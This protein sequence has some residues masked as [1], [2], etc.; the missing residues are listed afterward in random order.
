M[1]TTKLREQLL[2][3]L[4]T[5][6]DDANKKT[7]VEEAKTTSFLH[8]DSWYRD[9]VFLSVTDTTLDTFEV[10][11]E[12]VETREQHDLW[13]YFR[14][15]TSSI[16][17]NRNA[18]RNMRML[19]KHKTTQ[20]YIGILAL[21]G[22]V[23]RCKA[24][25]TTIGWTSS[26]IRTK[27]KYVMNIA[28]CVGL[29]PMS[30]N[31]NIG[32]L[33]V[34]LCFSRT[35][36]L[37]FKEKYGHDLACITTFSINGTSIQY[38]R[39]P[40]YLKYVGE[41]KGNIS[42]NI[43]DSLYKSCMDYLKDLKDTRAL[44]WTNKMYKV[45][46]VLS[47]LDIDVSNIDNS[48]IVR[49][50]GVYIGFISDDAKP[51][52]SCVK[53][54]FSIDY[55]TIDDVNTIVEWWKHR[56]ASRRYQHLKTTNRLRYKLEL[57]NV[58]KHKNL[59]DVKKAQLRNREQI[60]EEA[61]KEK[62]R[63]YMAKYRS[64]ETEI[65]TPKE[66]DLL[67]TQYGVQ[68]IV[69]NP[70]WLAGFVDGDG[71]ID[72]IDNKYLRVSICQCDPIVLLKIQQV[73]GGSL[74]QKIN[75]GTGSRHIYNL[76]LHCSNARKII[77]DIAN[78]VIIEKQKVDACLEYFKAYDMADPE[79]ISRALDQVACK[80]KTSGSCYE[81]VCYAYIAGLFDA[82]GEVAIGMTEKQTAAKYAIK[83][84]QQLDLKLLQ[85]ICNY[86]GFGNVNTARL[87]IYAKQHVEIFVY[88]VLPFTIV[89]R[90]QS[91]ALQACL[92]KTLSP[93][94]AV[95]K[96]KL[97]KH[98]VITIAKDVRQHKN[99]EQKS[100]Q[101]P[102]NLTEA[103]RGAQEQR[104][105]EKSLRMT[106]TGN[107][108]FQKERPKEHLI[109]LKQGCTLARIEKIGRKVTDEQ[110]QEIRAAYASGTKPH[111]IAEKYNISRQYATNVAKGKILLKEELSNEEL[112]TSML[113][114][115]H[116]QKEIVQEAVAKGKS[117][118][119][120][121]YEHSIK[122]RRKLPVDLIIHIMRDK[123]NNRELM[124]KAATATYQQVNEKV[125]EAMVKKYFNG[126]LVMFENEFP[127]GDCT[128]EE[129][130]RMKTELS[131]K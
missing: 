40:Q 52:L 110:I 56:W 128:W 130:T 118:K 94:D 46:K 33:L 107:P 11:I 60:G 91:L 5:S 73:Y 126:D 100:R 51:F 99:N 108:N 67:L 88:N 42:S 48:E 113:E 85:H 18:G 101:P 72:V 19:V 1:D 78:H 75:S 4:G 122:G 64:S 98:K 77:Q 89:K 62:Q 47:Y 125:T 14:V 41:T 105:K 124:P 57:I 49:K 2:R 127:V 25:D 95:E 44:A 104:N 90:A 121:G 59:E 109:H 129:F 38:D 102:R 26:S 39:I 69:V 54:E 3:Y 65:N 68:D 20:K 76:S 22:D 36:L 45:N 123:Y 37:K 58:V 131:Q 8:D 74:S 9:K 92:N 7:K 82:E 12:F 70:I 32:K 28:C 97:E 17:T 71:S 43:P 115:K 119:E 15:H 103:Q 86:I 55:D 106:G 120:V 13:E 16:R 87:S 84:T 111:D 50:R 24:R 61:Y 114:A 31:F 23:Y 66:I 6:Y 30:Y 10:D 80:D 117:S 116:K 21:A 79:M 29:Q 96:V 34:A 27:L 53:D 112:V 81:R 83:V 63:Q 35:V 93:K